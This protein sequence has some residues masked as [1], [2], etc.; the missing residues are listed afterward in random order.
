MSFI[1]NLLMKKFKC[2]LLGCNF[3]TKQK[4]HLK[5]HKS[6]VHD[7]NVKWFSCDIP[8]CDHKSKQKSNLKVH[9]AV[10]HDI[11]VKWFSCDISECGYKCK[12]KHH[13]KRHKANVH[14]IDVKWF[15][16]DIPGCDH[17]CKQKHHLKRHKSNVHDIG[18]NRCDVCYENRHSKILYE[19]NYGKHKICKKCYK[20]IT[21]KESRIEHIWSDHIDKYYGTEY[22]SSSDGSLNSNGG[23]QLYRPD[24][25]YISD[26]IVLLLECDENQHKWNIGDYSCDE[27]RISDIYDELGIRGKKLIVIRWNPDN[28]KPV[29]NYNKLNRK[30]R[31]ELMINVMKHVVENPPTE[32]IH[33]YY[34]FYDEDNERLSQNISHT[35]IY[36]N[37]FIST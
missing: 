7:I 37:D 26:D 18:N 33:I 1:I 4:S 17:K 11:D 36:D 32:M 31:L 9:K 14:E 22:L 23:C 6:F 10:I 29:E 21:G 13:L 19:D 2:D 20:T 27:K 28:Y 25:L 24:K 12:Q 34:L 3:K 8:G 16:C 35:L 30:G 5:R 15:S